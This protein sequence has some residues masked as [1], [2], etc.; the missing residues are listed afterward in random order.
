MSKKKV[1]DNKRNKKT[2]DKYWHYRQ[3]VQSPE[4]DVRFLQKCYRQLKKKTAIIFREDFCAAFA[5]SCEWVKMGRAY[6]AVGVDVDKE[7]L[8]YGQ[9][10]YLSALKP[11]ER[12]RI[13]LIQSNVLRVRSPKTD[14]IG[15][16]N[17]S[18]S[19]FKERKTLKKYFLNVLKSLKSQ[20]IFVL[21]CFG[22]SACYE[23][24]EESE[25]YKNFTYYWEQENFDPIFHQAMF[26]IHYKRKGEKKRKN[27]FSYDWRMWSIPEIRDLLE[28]VGFRKSHVYWEGND[29]KGGGNGKFTQVTKGEE[30]ESWIAYI[31]AEK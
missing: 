12:Q 21:D 9:T 23:A 8:E 24:N 15:V 29:N 26:R 7:P 1:S 20:G 30:C 22:G 5:I 28:E 19:V 27:V 18:Y 11:H 14:I 10:I 25:E 16:F 6:K 4:L 3:S 13:Q 17:F 31:V 2:F